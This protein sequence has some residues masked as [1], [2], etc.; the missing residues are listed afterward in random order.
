[1]TASFIDT[2]QPITPAE[3]ATWRV[4]VRLPES[5]TQPARHAIR[6]V[7]EG[8]TIRAAMVAFAGATGLDDP[9]L[10]RGME[11]ALKGLISERRRARLKSAERSHPP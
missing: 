7:L 2:M 9:D 4:Y 10:L 11:K 5:A 3:K 1:V 8:S 6:S